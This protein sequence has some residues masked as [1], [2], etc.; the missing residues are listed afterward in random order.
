[1]SLPLK[2]ILVLSGVILIA[3]CGSAQVSNT[4]DVSTPTISN[5]QT[6][7]NTSE[8]EINSNINTNSN[9]NS[10]TNTSTTNNST[11]TISEPAP[12][13]TA[14]SATNTATE[15]VVQNTVTTYSSSE[16]ASHNKS[17]DCWQ[18]I[19]SKVYNMTSYINKHPGGP[20]I[21]NGC[22][23]DATNMFNSVGAHS[24]TQSLLADYYIGDLK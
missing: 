4:Q 12:T 13:T 5:V 11:P 24:N 21:I 6:T 17:T 3:G 8:P 20:S 18:I 10:N 1:M 19:D 22:G 16:V 9:T 15:P 2:T 7:T 23:K 14:N